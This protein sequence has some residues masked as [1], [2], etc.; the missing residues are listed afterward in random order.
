[1]EKMTALTYIF[2]V[3]LQMLRFDCLQ[4]T[5]TPLSRIHKN[6]VK[7][8]GKKSQENNE[9]MEK[10]KGHDVNIDDDFFLPHLLEEM[11]FKWLLSQS[12]S[13]LLLL[14]PSF[15]FMS[16]A[17]DSNF[18]S[19]IFLQ[20]VFAAILRD[21]DF[22]ASSFAFSCCLH[23]PSSAC[24]CSFIVIFDLNLWIRFRSVSK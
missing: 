3:I 1:M 10:L 16:R 18:P 8:S 13:L 17:V 20:I 2:I 14:Y 7:T 5:R 22:F 4:H 15:S 24:D 9:I 12:M 21:F 23:F 11:I 19:L 6:T